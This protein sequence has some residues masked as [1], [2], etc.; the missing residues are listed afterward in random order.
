MAA[1]S[2]AYAIALA[3]AALA[4]AMLSLW[5]NAAYAETPDQVLA[6]GTYA[7]FSDGDGEDGMAAGIPEASSEPG[8]QVRV[9]PFE[10][11]AAQRLY[12][13][14][15]RDDTFTIQSVCSGLYLMDY[16]G[17]VVQQNRMA[18]MTQ[19]W[20]ASE[21][22]GGVALTNVGTGRQLA[23]EEGSL[24]TVEADSANAAGSSGASKPA[25]AA[26]A[27]G[28]TG[29]ADATPVTVAQRFRMEPVGL[30]ADECYELCDAASGRFLDVE[31]GSP[32]D[33]ANVQLYDGNGT[34]A[35]AWI[36]ADQGDGWYTLVNNGS[37]KALDVA[38]G[39][40]L[41]GANVQQCT[42]NGTDA[43]L[44][45]PDLRADGSMVIVNKGSGLLLAAAGQD[46]GGNVH[47][48]EKRDPSVCTWRAMET[49][50]SVL[51]GDAA[52]DA[53]I[54]EI[55]YRN[56]GDL[57]ACYTELIHMRGVPEMDDEIP[58]GIMDD[59][60]MR[61]YATYVMQ[62]NETDCY[63][64]AS[65]LTFIARACGYSANAIGGKVLA[66]TGPEVHGWTEVYVDGQVYV[67][68]ACLGRAAPDRNWF[69][70]TY[71]TAPA[72]YYP[73]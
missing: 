42:P 21:G 46:D 37:S 31:G 14:S 71:D 43:Q 48:A 18:T 39:S 5:P 4:F 65:A 72:E 27:S 24:V 36:A 70:V 29:S 59:A 54:R 64:A 32:Y 67:C 10:G 8:A 13:R 2:K 47:Q 6:Q 66:E 56:G 3:C 17:A 12:V 15:M 45:K 26:S 44:W 61:K 16:K 73:Q 7:A 53:Y 57:Q 60:T 23:V 62:R 41:A 11:T 28:E 33:G 20:R 30:L 1:V 68:D 58:M 63:G 51:T 52:L 35:Q 50:E 19:L 9:F 34:I 22:D 55:V 38:D 40:S 49:D 25:G 69:M